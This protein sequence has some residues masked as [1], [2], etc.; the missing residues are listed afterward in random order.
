MEEDWVIIEDQVILSTD[1]RHLLIDIAVINPLCESR[2]D[3]L[4]LGGVGCAATKW[5]NKK[6]EKYSDLD[7]EKYDFLPFIIETTGGMAK[8]AHGLCEELLK[9]QKSLSCGE[10]NGRKDGGGYTGLLSAISVELQR[11]NSHMV[12]ERIPDP[13]DLIERDIVKCEMAVARRKRDAIENLRLGRQRPYSILFQDGMGYKTEKD[14]EQGKSVEGTVAPKSNGSP[15]KSP[16]V[17]IT[18]A[19]TRTN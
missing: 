8:A 10:W 4:I 6:V 13:E 2:R 12:L 17:T 16:A 14:S 9:L 18:N 11:F 5:G 19:N 7:F 15:T 3:D 1:G